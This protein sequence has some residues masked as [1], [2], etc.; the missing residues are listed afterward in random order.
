MGDA[1]L[2][3]AIAAVVIGGTHMLGGRGRYLGTLLTSVLSIMPMPAGR[4]S[5]A[6]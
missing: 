4:S 5:T 3:P 6:R 2:L 1:Y